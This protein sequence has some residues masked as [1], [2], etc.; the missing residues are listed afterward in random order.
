MSCLNKKVKTSYQEKNRNDLYT[1]SGDWEEDKIDILP[2]ENDEVNKCGQSQ[3]DLEHFHAGNPSS[4]ATC[5]S[6]SLPLIPHFKNIHV[7]LTYTFHEFSK[8]E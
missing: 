3:S 6:S 1:D 5:V 2:S 4:N 7:Q 8:K